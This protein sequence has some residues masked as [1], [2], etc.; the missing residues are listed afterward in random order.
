MITFGWSVCKQIVFINTNKSQTREVKVMSAKEVEITKQARALIGCLIDER[1]TG[2]LLSAQFF[3]RYLSTQATLREAANDASKAQDLHQEC[4][5]LSTA[6]NIPGVVKS[7][8]NEFLS[9]MEARFCDAEMNS[10]QGE[11]TIACR[12]HIEMAEKEWMVRC[13]ASRGGASIFTMM[14][15]NHLPPQATKAPSESLT[16][17]PKR[18]RQSA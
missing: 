4:L 1:L 9:M 10:R 2:V 3:L 15:S 11:R 16:P 18:E 6:L 7:T 13:N 5:R 8:R 17:Q 12:D 14:R